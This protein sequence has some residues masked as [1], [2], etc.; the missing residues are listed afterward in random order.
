MHGAFQVDRSKNIMPVSE[1]HAKVTDRTAPAG[2]EPDWLSFIVS[3]RQSD[4]LCRPRLD[5]MQADGRR[6]EFNKLKNGN[7]LSTKEVN[8]YCILSCTFSRI[9]SPKKKV[10]TNITHT[11]CERNLFLMF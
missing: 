8:H 3:I 4:R 1:G 11:A 6:C 10:M 9:D 5:E 7:T 2:P